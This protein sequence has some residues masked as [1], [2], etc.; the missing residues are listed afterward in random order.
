MA[1]NKLT[2]ENLYLYTKGKEFSLEGMEYIGYYHTHYGIPYSQGKLDAASKRLYRYTGDEIIMQYDNIKPEFS[3]LASYIEPYSAPPIITPQN[4]Q[5]GSMTRYFLKKRNENI[6]I[7][8]NSNMSKKM[9]KA[10]GFDN[11]LYDLLKMEW[12]ISISGIT[13]ELLAFNANSISSAE[14]DMPGIRDQIRSLFEYSIVDIT[15]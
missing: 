8:I 1:I 7:E 10:G 12:K 15:P 14:M 13:N 3:K 6:I 9:G 5:D 2:G 4:Y 11:M